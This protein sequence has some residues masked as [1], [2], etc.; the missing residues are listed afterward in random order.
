MSTSSGR[1]KVVAD[2]EDA[3]CRRSPVGGDGGEDDLGG[4]IVLVRCLSRFGH[5]E[6]MPDKVLDE[7]VVLLGIV[8]AEKDLLLLVA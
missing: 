5:A 3:G 8:D 4:D 6:G 2:V 7:E 1:E